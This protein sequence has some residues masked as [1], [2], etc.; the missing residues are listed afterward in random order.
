[1][2]KEKLYILK[3]EQQLINV[4]RFLACIGMID[5]ESKHI[6]LE[7]YPKELRE[8]ISKFIYND[9]HEIVKK[10]VEWIESSV[11]EECYD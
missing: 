1:M 5:K 3:K 10:L 2:S 4:E 6:C 11:E 7:L 8:A 9:V